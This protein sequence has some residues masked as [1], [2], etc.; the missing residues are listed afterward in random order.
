MPDVVN[1]WI[2]SSRLK[3][4]PVEMFNPWYHSHLIISEKKYRKCLLMHKAVETHFEIRTTII[5]VP[6]WFIEPHAKP[7][8]V[9]VDLGAGVSIPVPVV[10]KEIDD[11]DLPWWNR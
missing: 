3:N 6:S 1:A 2:I 9:S 4:Q 8:F 11:K 5:Q 10:D 7:S